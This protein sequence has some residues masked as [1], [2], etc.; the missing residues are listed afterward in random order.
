M[1]EETYEQRRERRF[2]SF[3]RRYS[4]IDFKINPPVLDVGGGDGLFL[5]FMKIKDAD[6]LGFTDVKNKNY[7]YIHV[8]LSKKLPTLKKYKT[9]FLLQIL[10]HLNNPL[11][12]LAQI[13]DILD[14]NGN[15]YI[16]IPYTELLNKKKREEKWSAGEWDVGHVS[17]WTLKEI[18]NQT[19]KLGF[20]PQIL[21]TRRRFKGLAFW[22]PHCWIVLKI[23]K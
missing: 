8:D 21:T 20:N 23:T 9:I 22:L 17:R 19:K 16:S 11:Y 5:E 4:D 3:E 15:C 6:I 12:L 2:R 1:K 13:H 7:N 10:E 18:I 14:E